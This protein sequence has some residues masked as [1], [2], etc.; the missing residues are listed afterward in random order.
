LPIQNGLNETMKS[1]HDIAYQ[2]HF[3][4]Y[5]IEEGR[6]KSGETANEWNTSASALCL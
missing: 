2:F 4:D 1:F 3:L 6:R 5:L